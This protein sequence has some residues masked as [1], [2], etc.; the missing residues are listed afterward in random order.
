MRNIK[1]G[2]RLTAGFLLVSLLAAVVGGFGVFGLTN[3]SSQFGQEL[4][5]TEASL[6][7]LANIRE[8]FQ[9]E[10]VLLRTIIIQ[11]GDPQEAKAA[12]AGLPD[13]IK[14]I[15]DNFDA[16]D[17]NIIDKSSE[18]S[19]YDARRIYSGAYSTIRQGVVTAVVRGDM[20]GASTLLLSSSETATQIAKNLESSVEHNLIS[21]RND[22]KQLDRSAHALIYVL[23]FVSV[24]AIMLAVVLGLY[25]TD[26]ITKP[27][28]YITKA[29]V[30]LGSTGS[31]DFPADFHISS[32]ENVSYSDEIGECTKAILSVLAHIGQTTDA[33]G[34]VADGDL[35]VGIT[36]LSDRDSLGIALKKMTDN[37]N[38]MFDEIYLSS[39]M[40]ANGSKQ[41]ADGSQ[42]LAHGSA[43]QAAAVE[44]L[45]SSIGEI[46]DK[47]KE[48]AI[49]AEK[50][51]DLS[52]S[53]IKSAE[54][55]SGQMNQMIAAVKEISEAS[56]SI[57]KVI[58]VI[59]DIAFQTNILALN[60]AVEAARAGQQGKGFAV[61]AEEVRSLAAKSADAARDTGS[62]IENSIKKAALGDRIAKNTA[63]SLSEIVS[64]INE[65]SVIA[66]DIARLSEDQALAIDQIK[67]GINQVTQVVQQNSATAE[68][69]ASASEEMNS[70]SER[71]EELLSKF[72]LKRTPS[73]TSGSNRPS[74]I[75]IPAKP[76]PEPFP[77]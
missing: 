11:T 29:L 14:K 53:I 57:R 26:L 35:T 41:I 12:I 39:S 18:T 71:L 59:D 15:N 63:S 70:Q 66:K 13:V 40:V 72:R 24:F 67:N 21:A 5:Q 31:M 3:I 44:D 64:G 56:Q 54:K 58:K 75:R 46:A 47:T 4:S 49:K 65:S 73:Q 22:A 61:V 34:K 28:G 32:G 51:A 68:E 48:N 6:S 25:L 10:R 20:S 50:S 7:S 9:Q 1:I 23:I 52:E 42:M 55:G 69:S 45:S 77:Y 36:L 60:A 17:R 74:E 37:L 19:F 33:L 76:A 30:Q 8:G 38:N 62:L 27:L 2:T 43:Q 16:Y